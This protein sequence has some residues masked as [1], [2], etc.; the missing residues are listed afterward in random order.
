MVEAIAQNNPTVYNRISS[1][2][3]SCYTANDRLDALRSR[4]PARR[5]SRLCLGVRR[6][7]SA[8]RPQESSLVNND[9]ISSKARD[10]VCIISIC[11]AT[12]PLGNSR[13]RTAA[14]PRPAREGLK[15]LCQRRLW[16][17]PF[18]ESHCLLNTHRQK[19]PPVPGLWGRTR[20]PREEEGSN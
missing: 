19:T 7:L 8:S 20:V 10:G 1:V 3:C 5:Q 18:P 15:N 6:A 12:P 14:D 2:T 9:N 16:P 17:Q 11:L 13:R 4:A